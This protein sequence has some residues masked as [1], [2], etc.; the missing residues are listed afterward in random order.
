MREHPVRH[1]FLPMQD[2][3]AVTETSAALRFGRASLLSAV[4]VVVGTVAHL[5]AGGLL[6]GPVGMV[7]LVVVGA[8]AVAPLLGRQLSKLQVV[9]LL[10]G[11]QTVVHLALT[12][13]AGHQGQGGA[14]PSPTPTFAAPRPTTRGG[15]LFEQVMP[16]QH[17]TPLRTPDLVTHLIDDLS[18]P[19][20]LMAV[21]H[22]VAAAGVGL[23][24]ARG[25]EALWTVIRLAVRPAL[26]ST[27]H[28][29]VL[30]RLP[31]PGPAPAL[32]LWLQSRPVQ[33]RGPPR[34]FAL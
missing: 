1:P 23:W 18:G 3:G 34:S 21:A 27:P 4:C 14:Q 12:A 20:A 13:L 6:P 22:L 8:L 25:E 16:T 28:V 17:G 29:P 9:A 15:S 33:R 7:A 10:M 26:P 31:L 5:S 11:G 30:A 2:H 24:L 32:S 19:H